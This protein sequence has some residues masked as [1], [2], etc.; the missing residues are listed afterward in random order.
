MGSSKR[1]TH[2]PKPQKKPYRKPVLTV[3]G[4]VRRLT[5]GG[6]GTKNDGA[7]RLTKACWIAEALYGLDSPRVVLVRSWL[8]KHY[9]KGD[10][11]ALAVVPLYRRFGQGAATVIRRFPW[12]GNVFRPVFDDAVRRAA[13]EYA[14]D[15][16][17]RQDLPRS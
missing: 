14:S 1:T 16:R 3:Y 17:T 9:E 7:G 6:G 4:D 11:W 13:E 15:A 12:L 10:T 2:K 8:A 5:R